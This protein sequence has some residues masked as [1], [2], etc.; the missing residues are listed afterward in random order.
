[1]IFQILAKILKNHHFLQKFEKS[2]FLPKWKIIKFWKIIIFCQNLKN[3]Q[4]WPKFEKSS[5]F[6]IFWK[7]INFGQNLKNHHFLTK[8]ENFSICIVLFQ[9]CQ[10]YNTVTT[11]VLYSVVVLFQCLFG[12]SIHNLQADKNCPL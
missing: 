9:C 1:M 4:F 12:P 7:M 8:F 11:L 2:S 5:F 10:H 6:E 3:H